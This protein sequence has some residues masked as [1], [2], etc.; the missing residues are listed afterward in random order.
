MAAKASD[1]HLQSAIDDDILKRTLIVH[2]RLIEGLPER[3]ERQVLPSAVIVVSDISALHKAQLELSSLNSDLERRVISRTAALQQTNEDLAEE[4]ARRRATEQE[5]K[6]SRDEL[7]NLTEQLINAQEAERE[8]LSRELHDSLGQSLGAVKYSLESVV[9]AQANSG[10]GDMSNADL[11]AIV[12]RVGDLIRETRSLATGLRPHV[13]DELGIA[14]AIRA[15]C[16]QIDETYPDIEFHI[17]IDVSDDEVPP[18]LATPIYRIVQEGLGNVVKHASAES[19]MVALRLHGDVLCL[20]ILDDGVGFEDLVGGTGAHKAL[21]KL[22]RVGM[23]ERAAHSNGAL[24][25]ESWP[26][27]GTRIKAQWPLT[28]S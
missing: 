1:G 7:E 25:I 11:A 23:R 21:G 19:V 5:L 14:S 28:V 4:I 9:A 6:A 26:G 22:G 3:S 17:D 12:G 24:K 10:N 15:L 2:T 18:R 8:R 20:E 16:R 27:E 13:L